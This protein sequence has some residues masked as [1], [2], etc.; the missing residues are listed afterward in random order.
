MEV[1]GKSLAY[2]KTLNVADRYATVRK[3]QP[4]LRYTQADASLQSG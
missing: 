1:R 2:I 3:F 4:G